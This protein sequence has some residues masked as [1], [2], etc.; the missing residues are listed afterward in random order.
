MTTTNES[1]ELGTWNC[2][3]SGHKR[4]D[5]FH[6]NCCVVAQQLQIWIED[7]SLKSYPSNTT[8]TKKV[9]SQEFYKITI[10]LLTVTWNCKATKHITRISVLLENTCLYFLHIYT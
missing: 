4:A 6:A 10:I 8:H 5:R 3:D 7:G 1:L 9:L 2:V